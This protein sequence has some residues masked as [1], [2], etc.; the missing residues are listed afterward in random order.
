MEKVDAAGSTAAP[1][2]PFFQNI[3]LPQQNQSPTVSQT[4]R[5]QG[6]F[7]GFLSAL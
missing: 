5:L 4:H 7:R 1:P 6:W 3:P 2:A